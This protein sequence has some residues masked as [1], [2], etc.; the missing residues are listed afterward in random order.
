[1]LMS[2]AL[3]GFDAMRMVADDDRV[4]LP[5]LSHPTASGHFVTHPEHGFSHYVYYGQMQRL[6]GA[7][8]SIYIN[9]GGR[10]QVSAG[11]CIE[12]R[13]G[14]RDVMGHIRPI[15]PLPGGGMTRE[16]IADL[17]TMYGTEVI[18][19]VGGGLHKMGPDLA[20]NVRQLIQS[21]R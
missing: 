4:G 21:V 3:T 20:E 14:C 6:A 9:Q 8:A 19:L 12:A 16:R 18:F 11:D 5:I 7:D 10:F 1:L 17:K 15:M 2:P 13:D